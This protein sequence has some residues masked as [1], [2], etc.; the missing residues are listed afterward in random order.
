M[1]PRPPSHLGAR[2]QSAEHFGHPARPHY[3]ENRSESQSGGGR[4]RR[5][6]S[7]R[8]YGPGQADGQVSQSALF[9]TVGPRAR[10]RELRLVSRHDSVVSLIDNSAASP[11]TG[12]PSGIRA[13]N[14]RPNSH[15]GF[16]IASARPEV[17]SLRVFTPREAEGSCGN[18]RGCNAATRRI[19]GEHLVKT[20]R[21]TQ[22]QCRGR[23]SSPSPPPNLYPQTGS[24]EPWRPRAEIV[25]GKE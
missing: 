18:L 7:P 11:S 2:S 16:A 23:G 10:V 1:A 24:Q 6:A 12:A 13:R 8:I 21:A 9:P 14:C 17:L 20:L 25:Q 4:R 15:A 3:Q 22:S 5:D 19:L